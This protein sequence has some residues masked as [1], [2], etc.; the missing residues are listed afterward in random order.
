LTKQ[1]IEE[2]LDQAESA[3]HKNRLEEAEA[4]A[5]RTFVL[6]QENLEIAEPEQY[7]R[8][9]LT[10]SQTNWK[11][12]KAKE[13]MPFAELALTLVNKKMDKISKLLH[14]KVLGNIGAVHYCFSDNSLAL[15][16][17]KKALHFFE[18]IDNKPGVASMMGSIGVIHR[19]NSDYPRALEYMNKSLAI[20]NELGDKAGAG[21]NTSNIGNVYM[22]LSDYPGALEYMNIALTLAKELGNRKLESDIIGN[23]GNVSIHLADYA[24]ALD[25]FQ[26]ALTYCEEIGNKASMASHIGNIGLTYSKLG[27][28]HHSFEYNTRALFLF[29]TIE[30]KEG[31]ANTLSN[32]GLDYINLTDYDRALE[33]FMQALAMNELM[34]NKVRASLNL[35]NMG[36]V[37]ALQKNYDRA[38]EQFKRAL[39][40]NEEL[41]NQTNIAIML[42]NIGSVFFEIADY[43]R[44]L[45]Y[46]QHAYT[47]DENLG[48][49]FGMAQ[50]AHKI[51]QAHV[52]LSNFK[53]AFDYC[54]QAIASFT[55]LGV[56][57]ELYGVLETLAD[58]Y[59][60]QNQWKEYAEYL[61]KHHQLYIE[62]QNEEVRKQADRFGWE[63]KIA[64]ME[65]QKE[66]EAIK[67][68]AEKRIF[69]ETISFQKQSLEQQAREVKNTV[70]ELVRKN[71]LLQLIHSDLRKIAPHTEREGKDYIDQLLER[72]TRNI[73]PLESN[74]QLDKQLTEVH[75]EFIRNLHQKFPDLTTM[76]LKIAALLSMKLTSSNIAAALFLAKRTVESHRF[77]LRKKMGLGT[78]D[79]IYQVLAQYAA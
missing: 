65:K 9:L 2:L 18:K 60:Q 19:Q 72:V 32:I 16:Y 67:N 17:F 53:I 78:S 51:G 49:Q 27:N 5:H 55:K 15:K 68:C 13:A 7:C 75:G 59:K 30:S 48:N 4:L 29:E 10:L 56:K 38:L 24:K 3:L 77:S 57:K 61:N 66:I 58:L 28:F 11:S 20:N 73:T 6:I 42:G 25:C 52:K 39:S 26:Q 1:E 74:Q 54:N 33:Y 71:S 35:C 22:N 79:D 62:V 36:N 70:D 63:R 47:I 21:Y 46:Y 44:A 8:V 23:I 69:E 76:E 45:E 50:H 12:G 41:G 37:Y 34:G 14:A 40:I 64:G 43:V 31:I